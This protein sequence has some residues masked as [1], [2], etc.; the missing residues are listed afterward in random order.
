MQIITTR[1][2]KQSILQ[3][4]IDHAI[5]GPFSGPLDAIKIGLATGLTAP[6]DENLTLAGVTEASFTGYARTTAAV[7]GTI[8]FDSNGVCV[9]EMEPQPFFQMT[10]LTAG[11]QVCTHMIGLNS[12]GTDLLFAA[13]LDEPANFANIGDG[14][15]LPL[16][17][18]SLDP[19]PFPSSEG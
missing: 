7:W 16:Q 14:L 5:A 4:L 10:A 8:Y 18:P 6:L 15:V 12:A 17:W 11:A 19:P 3:A 13:Q 1:A 9:V 2:L